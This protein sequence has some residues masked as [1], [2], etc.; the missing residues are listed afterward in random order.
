M[1]KETPILL[2]CDL[3]NTLMHSYKHYRPGD[4]CVEWKEDREQGYMTER[5]VDLLRQLPDTVRL[6]P[7]TS[8]SLA[9]YRRIR[10]PEGLEPELA[11][12]ANGGLL[13]RNGA[14]D[15]DWQRETLRETAPLLPAFRRLLG[16]FDNEAAY[17]PRIVDDVYFYVRAKNGWNRMTKGTYGWRTSPL[18]VFVNGHKLYLF[19]TPADKG[20]GLERLRRLLSPGFVISAGDS[21][22]DRPMLAKA[23]LAL[24]PG[25]AMAE[26]LDGERTRVCPTG[27][28]FAEF[29]LE[30]VLAAVR[31]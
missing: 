2:A 22:I 27:E 31:I 7:V 6:V 1:Y 12:A 29:V 20:V 10:W 26:G 21:A 23:D 3:D 15:P 19:P 16:L 28:P 13:L 14:L 11:L 17:Q 24:V 8:R 18:G 25:Q 4:V 5:T 30:Q 9:Q